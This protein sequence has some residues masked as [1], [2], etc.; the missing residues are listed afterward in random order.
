MKAISGNRPTPVLC[1]PLS[2]SVSMRRA[3]RVRLPHTTPINAA[4]TPYTTTDTLNEGAV[5]PTAKSL[6]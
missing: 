1:A 3:P 4:V 6:L 2:A 5:D